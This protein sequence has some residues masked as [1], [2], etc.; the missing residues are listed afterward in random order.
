MKSFVITMIL[1][2]AM[3]LGIVSNSLY[4]NN[5]VNRM[6]EMLDGL[7]SPTHPSCGEQA[8]AL[9]DF[10]NTHTKYVNL[11]INYLIADRVTEQAYLLVSAAEAGDLYGYAAALTLLRDA[12]EDLRRLESL[13]MG[14]IL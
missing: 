3:L 12:V 14:S 4:I 13:T 11:S 8:R 1:L 6:Q 2:V 7:P 10:W 9:L 5:V